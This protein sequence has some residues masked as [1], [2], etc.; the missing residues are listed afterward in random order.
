M[1]H[2]QPLPNDDDNDDYGNEEE[3]D[4]ADREPAVIREPSK[5]E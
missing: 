3:E 1:L 5:D 4:E 2:K